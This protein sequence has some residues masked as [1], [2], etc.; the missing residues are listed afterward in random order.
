[1]KRFE[2]LKRENIAETPENAALAFPE[3]S[4]GEDISSVGG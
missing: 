1:L 3:A 2:I 4:L